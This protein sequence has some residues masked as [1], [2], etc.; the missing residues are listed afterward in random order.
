MVIVVMSVMYVLITGG[1]R[2]I[3][4]ATAIRFGRKGYNICFTYYSRVKEAEELAG[5]LESMGVKA[6]FTRM[7]VGSPESVSEG[8]KFFSSRIPYLN[9]LVNNAGIISVNRFDDITI[10]EWNSIIRVNLTGVY[11]VTKAF[12][13]LLRKAGR[14]SIVNVASLAGQTGNAVASVAYCASKAGVIGFTRRLAVELGP[15]GIRVNAVAPSFVETDMVREFINTEEKRE[16]VKSLH[17]LH[18]I[19]RPEDIANA[20]YFLANE[21]SRFI[22]GEV[23]SVNGGRLTC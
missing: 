13:P 19:A 21:D 5:L 15:K 20:I 8:L 23:L 12:L 17:S 6:F 22:T 1:D 2:G 7:D 4:R 3:G 9:V 16:R 10:D 18:D 11:L 14:A